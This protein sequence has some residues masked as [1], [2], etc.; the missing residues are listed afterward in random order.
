[1]LIALE[2]LRIMINEVITTAALG[3]APM[4]PIGTGPTYPNPPFG[5]PIKRR[6]NNKKRKKKS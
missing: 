3:S 1:M 5:S 6:K 4:T 2:D